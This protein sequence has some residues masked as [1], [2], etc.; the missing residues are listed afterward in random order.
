M[1]QYIAA[2][3]Q[4]AGTELVPL[5]KQTITAA[6]D[7][8]AVKKAV[9]WQTNTVFA[10]SF[11]ERTWLQVLRDGLPFT[12]KSWGDFEACR[13]VRLMRGRCSWCQKASGC[14]VFENSE[15]SR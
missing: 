1:P 8:E 13:M 3:C 5:E 9:H 6:N 14:G 15:P 2:L 7:A 11:D 12:R 4:M 10:I